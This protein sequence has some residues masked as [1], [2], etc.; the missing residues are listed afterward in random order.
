MGKSRKRSKLSHTTGYPYKTGKSPNEKSAVQ[1]HGNACFAA[2]P[3][4]SLQQG[5]LVHSNDDNLKRLGF[6][7]SYSGFCFNKSYSLASSVYNTSLAYTPARL[8]S[9]VRAVEGVITEYTVPVVSAVQSSSWRALY[10]LDHQV[11]GAIVMAHHLLFAKQTSQANQQLVELHEARSNYLQ[12]LQEG[13]A[14]LKEHG[15]VETARYAADVMLGRFEPQQLPRLLEEEAED[16][17]QKIGDAW[18]KIATIPPVAK[19]VA[20]AQPPVEFT[21]NKYREA[22]SAVVGSA[23][24]NRALDI[25]DGVVKRV[26]ASECDDSIDSMLGTF[27]C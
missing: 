9:S 17:V 4:F 24:Y 25:A 15:L 11:D 10:Q 5:E 14:F 13:V 26:Q 16:L 19:V 2:S 3:L 12:G 1:L 22:H 7:Q 8:N 20:T 23:A 18:G 6:V 21:C 27:G